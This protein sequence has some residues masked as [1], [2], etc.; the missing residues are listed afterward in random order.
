[1]AALTG[2][3]CTALQAPLASDSEPQVQ[4]RR[5]SRCWIG[6][7]SCTGC[8]DLPLAQLAYEAGQSRGSSAVFIIRSGPSVHTLMTGT[9]SLVRHC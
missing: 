1:M 8:G 6:V 7:Q 3:I 9:I 2:C 5:A 4:S